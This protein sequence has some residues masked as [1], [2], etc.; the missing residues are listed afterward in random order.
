MVNYEVNVEISL[1]N[2]KIKIDATFK[3]MAIK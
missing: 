3:V 2:Q 1:V